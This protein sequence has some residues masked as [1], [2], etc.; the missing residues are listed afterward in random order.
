MAT[1]WKEPP[2]ATFTGFL[3]SGRERKR[4]HEA[5]DRLFLQPASQ[6]CLPRARQSCRDAG[7]VAV[8]VSRELPLQ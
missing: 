2:G 6:P 1:P 8:P 4:A 7:R 5:A 3:V